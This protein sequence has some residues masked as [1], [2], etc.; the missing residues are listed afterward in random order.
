MR[1]TTRRITS[2]GA[3]HR[4]AIAAAAVASILAACSPGPTP[5]PS[6]AT[7]AAPTLVPS[8]SVALVAMTPD[9]PPLAVDGTISE[10]NLYHDSRSDLYR[11]PGGAVPAGTAVTLRIR[12]G[13]GDLTD[14]T[15]RVWDENA[16]VQVLIPM[17]VVATDRTGGEHGYDY[18]EATLAT[19]AQPDLYRYRFIVRDGPTTRYLEDDVPGPNGG[20][21]N[22]GG[23]GVVYSESPDSS[24][25]IAAYKP[26][27]ATP[28]WTHGAVVYQVFPDRFFNG[29]PSNDPS[30]T[31]T[32]GTSGADVYRQ[33]TDYGMPIV[34]KKWTELPEGYC[35]AYKGVTCTEIPKGRDYFGGDLDGIT[36]KLDDLRDLG[37]TV[38]YVNP[39][40]AASSNHRYD[41]LDYRYVDPG[42]GT[43]ADFDAL[44]AAAKARGIRVVLD[45]VFN[46]VSSSSPYFDR[47]RQYEA[48]GACESAD[49][50]YR[51]WFTFRK[52]D[53]NEPSPCAPSTPGGDDTYY[54]GW[55]GFDTIP[56]L[57]ES[58]DTNAVFVASTG[59]VPTWLTAG[60][61]G[62]RLDVMDNLSHG[63]VKAIRA[64][65][66]KVDED[67][68]VLGETWGDAS[69]W[70]LGNE[71]DS[72]MNYRFRRAVI[73]LVNG[74]TDDLD[75]R[76]AGLTPSA[77]ASRMSGV[78]EEYPEPAWSSLLNLVDSHDTTRILWTL[79][80]G[81]ENEAAKTD[82]T[83]LAA[84]KAKLRQVAA[85][86]LTWP[87]MASI[88][89]GDEVG[90]TG[91]DD[92][93]D[94]RTYPWDG[95]DTELRDWYRLIANLRGRLD[96]LKTGDLR[97]L[98]ADDAA[99]TL[100]FGRR[101]AT[102]AAVTALNLSDAEE[103]VTIPVAGYIPD[104]AVL[105]SAFDGVAATVAG[106]SLTVT[107]PARGSALLVTRPGVDLV[108]PAAPA[109]LV[110]AAS[111]ASVA[112]S[113]TSVDGAAGYRVLRSILPG[114]YE[115]IGT[116][117]EAAF[118]DASARPGTTWHYV[119]EA[120][121]A[122][123]NAGERSADVAA[124]PQLTVADA[125]LD[126]PAMISQP[127]SATG[128]GAPVGVLVTV[129]GV[130]GGQAPAVG[131]RVQLGFGPTG[132]DPTGDGW[133]WTRAAWDGPADGADR[134][135]GGVRP[136]A[137][138]TYDVAGRVSTDGGGRWTYA[139]RSAAPN[140]PGDGVALTA[141]PG[142]DSQAP[143]APTGVTVSAS[144]DTSVTLT[145]DPVAA[146]DL[147]RYQ[148][149]RSGTAGGPYAPVGT[150]I[151]PTFTDDAVSKG[152]T[153]YYVVAAQDTSYNVSPDSAEIAS[154][155][156][157]RPVTVT[158]RV[159][160]PKDTPN[161]AAVFIAGDFQGWNPGKTPMRRAADGT[162]EIELPFTE[163]Q[164]LQYKYTRGSWE[165]VEKDAGCG[166]IPNRT[167]TV[168]Y[169]TDGTM[170]VTDEAAKWRDIARCG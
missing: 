24:W 9:L 78:M 147:L 3:R 17:K 31:A 153:Y 1:A 62:W 15:V 86:Q 168:T 65:A 122:A 129:P 116:T 141:V 73:G 47:L 90:L 58:P 93:D 125:R 28:D 170:L 39:I 160:V 166:E 112:L 4:A 89:Y 146:P 82:P 126:G 33:P 92:P 44:V 152:A 113:W 162:W 57:V 41:T 79:T 53:A 151:E 50:P 148:V 27:F 48:V 123:G 108:G 76:I 103:T 164:A 161:D 37:V 54:V 21:A 42:L 128:A 95:Q 104:G 139:L 20:E 136:E 106:G 143:P 45:G 69:R 55:F 71:A 88:Y 140:A 70:L 16:A 142:A 155:A 23:T 66:K 157:A 138:G 5:S 2:P 77:F 159:T 132:S 96:A 94:R 117:G 38:L 150:T 102:Q 75:G 68:L 105:D 145:W 25:E 84:G 130:T 51:S 110:A 67:A 154:A 118:S 120:L 83:A 127:L 8:P 29:D 85:L 59:V 137:T 6:A 169:G 22:D 80:P 49:S 52:P 149:S 131:I 34:A 134:Y 13:A 158:F 114:G 19:P 97:F 14:A 107:L 99:G 36:A 119:V 167:L 121:D 124:L 46:H 144:S 109:G 91:Q 72:V 135:V 7:P 35:R 100:A 63:L 81:A 10:A 87:G 26:G 40:F 61:S 43:R 11:S 111:P 101:T 18:W 98:L 133:T 30:P 32:P 115:P 64:A 74:P 60:A 163:G 12:A 156:Q 165:A 56:E